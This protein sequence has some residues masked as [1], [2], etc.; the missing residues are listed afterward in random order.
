L[1]D[2]IVGYYYKT[3]IFMQQSDTHVFATVFRQG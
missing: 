3:R 1:L 2:A